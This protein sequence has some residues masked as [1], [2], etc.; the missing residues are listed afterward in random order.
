M[1]VRGPYEPELN[2]TAAVI[3]LSE[4]STVVQ[5][6]PMVA[7]WLVLSP[8]SDRS[9]SGLE[10]LCWRWLSEEFH[11][12]AC[13]SGDRKEASVAFA[14]TSRLT[15]RTASATSTTSTIPQATLT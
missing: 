4:H 15:G 2:E 13:L 3:T 1:T 9:A 7:V 14:K 8:N 11:V 10:P 6:E 12:I 5:V